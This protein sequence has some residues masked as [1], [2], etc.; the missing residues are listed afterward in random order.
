MP[1]YAFQAVAAP[2]QLIKLLVGD[3]GDLAVVGF[4]EMSATLSGWILRMRPRQFVGDIQFAV[5]KPTKERRVGFIEHLG[6]R[7]LPENLFLCL[8]RRFGQS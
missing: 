1:K 3:F 2:F 7:L 6:E 4:K 5:G 8:L